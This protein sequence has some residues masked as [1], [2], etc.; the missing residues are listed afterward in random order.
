MLRLWQT[1]IFVRT[2]EVKRGGNRGSGLSPCALHVHQGDGTSNMTDGIRAHSDRCN[3]NLLRVQVAVM[4]NKLLKYIAITL[5]ILLQGCSVPACLLIFNNSEDRIV[6][7]NVNRS[8]SVCTPIESYAS[9][10]MALVAD[11]PVN[12]WRITIERGET[13]KSYSLKGTLFRE[14]TVCD[15]MQCDIPLQYDGTES[16]HLLSKP[17]GLPAKDSP[18]QQA[19]FQIMPDVLQLN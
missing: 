18:V 15:G 2:I 12:S 17:T 3:P 14:V 19:G 11:S 9:G 6:V 7:C 4:Q 5:C 10:R 1:T 8:P 16:L 13:T